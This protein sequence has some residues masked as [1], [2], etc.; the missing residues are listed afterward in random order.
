M[1]RADEFKTWLEERGAKSAG[2]RSSRTSALGRIEK[3][4][5]ELGMPFPD[6]D[7][8]W[9]EDRFES[10]IERLQR[11]L[12]DAGHGGQDYRILMPQSKDPLN[13]LST[14]SGYLKRY[15]QFLDGESPDQP[16]SLSQ[17]PCRLSP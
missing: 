5:E 12:E 11:M 8:A 17:T 15:G 3:K 4:L 1:I 13:R 2:A 7:A 9:K 6:L 10:L 16:N 14:W